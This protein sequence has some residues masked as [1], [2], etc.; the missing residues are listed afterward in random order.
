MTSGPIGA[1]I[2]PTRNEAAG[3]L[4]FLREVD[5]RIREDG[6]QR[7][8][9]D[10]I[11]DDRFEVTQL[12]DSIRTIGFLPV[13]RLV[14]TRLPLAGKYVVI[15]GNRRTYPSWFSKNRTPQNRNK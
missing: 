15:E 12:K 6:V 14:V 3:T 9:L 2:A 7:K 10:R 11:L 13:D 8:A 1:D 4:G 5:D